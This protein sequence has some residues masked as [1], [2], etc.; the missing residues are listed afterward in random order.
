MI[1]RDQTLKKLWNKWYSKFSPEEIKQEELIQVWQNPDL[2][3]Y[4]GLLAFNE[5]FYKEY[6]E[7][8]LNVKTVQLKKNTPAKHA[9]VL[10]LAKDIVEIINSFDISIRGKISILIQPVL[11]EV[12]YGKNLYSIRKLSR[13]LNVSKSS[14]LRLIKEVRTQLSSSSSSNQLDLES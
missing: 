5:L 11:N 8:K 6:K 2:E 14:L 4:Q 13:E 1:S 10:L 9:G 7:K 12:Y 3:G